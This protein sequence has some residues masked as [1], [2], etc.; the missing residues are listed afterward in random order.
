MISI[1]IADDHNLIRKGLR[2]IFENEID[3]N[4]VGETPDPY[5]IPDLLKNNDVDILLLDLQ[6]PERSG[7]DV[8]KDIKA[9][10]PNLKVLI[11]SMHPEERYALRALKAGASGYISKDADSKYI[12]EAI[13]RIH[14]G[15]KYISQELSEQL[16]IS[17][18]SGKKLHEQL[19][20]RE[21]QVFQK[22]AEGKSQTNIANEL[23]LSISTINTYKGRIL[24]KLKLNSTSDLI[25]YAIENNLID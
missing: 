17:M 10:H 14:S 5:K 9:F 6:F 21:F 7:L 13:R 15:K 8:L 20:D 24:E 16:L 23:L 3:I 25:R 11:L 12:L 1:I 19:S 2:K 18:N 22:I 4:I